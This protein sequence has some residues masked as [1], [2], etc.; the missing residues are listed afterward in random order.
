MQGQV[1][2]G[3]GQRR[4]SKQA[5]SLA[6]EGRVRMC[7]YACPCVGASKWECAYGYS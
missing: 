1:G 3:G 6:R 7:A 5:G 2:K 4:V